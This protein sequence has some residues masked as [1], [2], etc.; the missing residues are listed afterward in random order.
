MA[1]KDV[2]D[3]IFMTTLDAAASW[4]RANSLLAGATSPQPAAESN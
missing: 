2:P 1:M 4:A 3:N